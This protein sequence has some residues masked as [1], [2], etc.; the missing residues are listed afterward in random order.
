[1]GVTSTTMG[2]PNVETGRLE[3]WK[4]GHG[5]GAFGAQRGELGPGG[6]IR[7]AWKGSEGELPPISTQVTSAEEV[8][9]ALALAKKT[10]GK[11]ELT[12][13]CAGVGI[14]VK[15]YNAKKDKVHEL[16]DFQRVINVSV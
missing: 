1:M 2:H 3:G 16:E 13:N 5:W 6:G 9:A 10:F 11:L 7:G 4:L 15:T 12:V 14:A 8:E